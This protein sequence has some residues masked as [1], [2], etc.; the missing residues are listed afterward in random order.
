MNI[1]ATFL[2]VSLLAV[3]GNFA[4]YFV[5]FPSVEISHLIYFLM[6]KGSSRDVV[7]VLVRD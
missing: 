2:F 4:V 5:E 7:I 1:I 3:T 6:N